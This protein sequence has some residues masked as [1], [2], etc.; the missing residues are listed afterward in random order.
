M[1][2]FLAYEQRD[3][4]EAER[5]HKSAIAIAESVNNL[6][7]L[8]RELG[9]LANVYADLSRFEEAVQCYEKSLAIH[10]RTGHRRS[11]SIALG[12]LALLQL[13]RG[14]L[15]E[16]ER[17]LR[18]AIEIDEETQNR[19]PEGFHRCELAVCLLKGGNE[20]A[21]RESWQQG[22]DL[23]RNLGEILAA[24]EKA[25]DMMAACLEAEV[26]PFDGTWHTPMETSSA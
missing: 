11:E 2:G 24:E 23:L 14:N 1:L 17:L 8:G 20:T 10:K 6:P 4:A 26:K 3:L 25:K 18:A 7:S 12:G 5:K 22:I 16:T 19:R 21:A 9:N 13:Q 15:Q